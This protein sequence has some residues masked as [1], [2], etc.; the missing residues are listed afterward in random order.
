IIDGVPAI[1]PA[2]GEVTFSLLGTAADAQTATIPVTFTPTPRTYN[3]A[4]ADIL[5]YVGEAGTTTLVGA[6]TKVNLGDEI[7]LTDMVLHTVYEIEPAVDTPVTIGMLSG[8]TS[9]ATGTDSIG[10]KTITVTALDNPARSATFTI[11]VNDVVNDFTLVAPG[12]STYEWNQDTTLDLTGGTVQ[13]IMQSALPQDAED[14][15]AAMLSG[16][17]LK[18]LGDQTVTVTYAGFTDTFT[19]TVESTT[20]LN[21]DTHDV[22]GVSVPEDVT[23]SD[24]GATYAADEVTMT[25]ETIA[26][27][28]EIEDLID[29][30]SQFDSV[31]ADNLLMVDV[32]LDASGTAVQPSGAVR[33]Y[34]P[35]PAGASRSDTFRVLHQTG[36]GTCEILTAHTTSTGIWFD[37]THFSSFAIGW[38][39]KVSPSTGSGNGSSSDWYDDNTDFWQTVTDQILDARSGMTVRVDAGD[40]DRM[41]TSVMAALRN[42][43]V[44]LK[45]SWDGGDTIIIPAGKAQPENQYRLY[46]PLSLLEDLYSGKVADATRIP[47]TGGGV[48]KITA[49]TIT[50]PNSEEVTPK[51]E[52]M[53]IDEPEIVTI[54][55]S[56]V[57]AVPAADQTVAEAPEKNAPNPILWAIVLMGIVALAGGGVWFAKRRGLF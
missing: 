15:T 6:P 10:S 22:P 26:D 32:S 52:G 44:T 53:I 45:I 36:I 50:T 9:G 55:D 23:F 37:V 2:T 29:D 16:Y 48:I 56:E 24:G 12:M 51:D 11:T 19:I 38:I 17:N 43:D 47:E 3:I 41:S 1:D 21:E 4:T 35:L 46:Y 20:T 28:S 54:P 49:P 30:A 40:Y 18:T 5:V 39:K 42:S 34:L 57:T 31:P 14:I 25:V 27:T 13:K 8:Y 7:D 33:V